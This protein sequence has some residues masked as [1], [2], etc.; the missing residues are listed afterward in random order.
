MF[1]F[2]GYPS[3]VQSA[4]D[5]DHSFHKER[6]QSELWTVTRECS[7]CLKFF[8]L[9]LKRFNLGYH[10]QGQ[11]A[12]LVVRQHFIPLDLTSPKFLNDQFRLKYVRG[13]ETK[14]IEHTV[15]G[16]QHT[17]LSIGKFTL[18]CMASDSTGPVLHA[19]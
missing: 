8:I 1:C 5:S 11:R 7:I 13:G 18:Y 12:F 6:L 17:S 9:F 2:K 19:I 10:A 15:C 4:T 14:W 3:F 16:T